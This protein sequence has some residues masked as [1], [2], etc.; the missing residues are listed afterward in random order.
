MNTKISEYKIRWN[1]FFK[2]WNESPE[3]AY[4]KSVWNKNH[5]G[6]GKTELDPFSLPQPYLG[7]PENCSAIT[8]NLNPGPTNDLRFHKNGILVSKFRNNENY[9]EYAKDY[10]QMRLNEHPSHFWNNQ[11]RWIDEIINNKNREKLPFA[12][13]ICPWHSIKWKSLPQITEELENFINSNVFEIITEAIK[14]SDLK[15]VLSV[16]KTYYDLFQNE[17]KEEFENVIEF[18]PENHS[19]LI[20]ITWP[21]NKKG[22]YSNRFFSVWKHKKTDIIYF[23]TYSRGSNKPPSNEWNEIQLYILKNYC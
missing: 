5:N 10:P 14:Y 4:N 20:N 12:I 11:F 15:T 22:N 17:F 9:F 6:K 13:E 19:E 23:N 16:G 2:E 21:K 8:L 7:N 3:E 1:D 18:S